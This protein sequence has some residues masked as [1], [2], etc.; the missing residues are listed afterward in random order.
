[1]AAN[2]FQ[3][4]LADVES[5]LLSRKRLPGSNVP[6][7][8]LDRLIVRH[9]SIAAHRIRG[10]DLQLQGP[11]LL[12]Q[13]THTR[14]EMESLGFELAAV[15]EVASEFLDQMCRDQQIEQKDVM[16]SNPP[17]RYLFLVPGRK[18]PDPQKKPGRYVTIYQVVDGNHT[19][20][21]SNTSQSINASQISFVSWA[22]ST[23]KL[24]IFTRDVDTKNFILEMFCDEDAQK[25]IHKIREEYTE[26]VKI[27]P[28]EEMEKIIVNRHANQL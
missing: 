9:L 16:S 25:L 26:T 11:L 28:S 8:G 3:K 12:S 18:Q 6:L 10:Y 20:D 1:M 5:L 27:V 14:K 21:A 24:R 17:N 23:N 13:I 19:P 7:V 15:D 2:E 22:P 4:A